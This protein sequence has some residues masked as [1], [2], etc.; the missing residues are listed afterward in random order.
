M[1]T[2]DEDADVLYVGLV[3]GDP[4][5]ARTATL[6]DLRMI[7][8]SSDGGVLGIEFVDATAGIDLRDIPFRETVERL[9]GESGLSIKILA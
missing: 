9:I 5:V 1:V 2:Y 7:D 4:S 3:E 8:Y 6:D